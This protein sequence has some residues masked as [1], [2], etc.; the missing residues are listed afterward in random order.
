MSLAQLSRLLP[1]PDEELQQ[2]LDYAKTLSKPE[3][4]DHFGNLLGESPDA[5]EFISSFNSRRQDPSGSSTS[6]PALTA[7]ISSRNTAIAPAPRG[8][9]GKRKKK[10]SIHTPAPRQISQVAPAPGAAYN[11]KDQH[12]D[13]MPGRPSQA[14]SSNNNNSS[15]NVSRTNTPPAQTQG[16]RKPKAPPSAAGTL[17][18]D[19]PK[20]N[21]KSNPASRT[22]TP[23]PSASAPSSSKPTK[24]TVTGGTAMHGASTAV[25]DLDAAIRAL[26]ITTSPTI[27]SKDTVSRKCDCVAT[28]HPLQTAAPNCLNCGKVICLKEGLGPCTHCGAGLLAADDIQAVISSLKA[29]RGREKMAADK[30]AHRKAEVSRTPAPFTKPRTGDGSG[31]GA[32][33]SG[34]EAALSAAE[35]QRD[36]LLDFQAENAKRTTVRDEAAD[37]DYSMA[38]GGGGGSMWASPEERAREL[39]RQQKIMR[40]MEWNAR[41]EYEKRQQVVSIDVARGKV[42]RK[43]AAVERPVW[44]DNDD[45]EQTEGLGGSGSGGAPL[46]ESSGNSLGGGVIGEGGAFSRNPLLGGVIKPM[47]DVRG[48]GTSEGRKNRQ[49]G[50]RKAQMDDDD[51][52]GVILDGGAYGGGVSG[53][54]DAPE[55]I[56]GGDEPACG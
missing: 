33:G 39:K 38:S 43:M 46:R 50:W 28:R 29:D 54:A 16:H 22:S 34:G 35:A 37:F 8:R 11:K 1:L 5:V 36:R 7:A 4:A 48:K 9:G 18:S 20:A 49:K 24:V 21:P 13:Y 31:A 14:T 47:Y 53:A 26:E 45:E 55:S 2:V 23:G 3:A 32:G 10:F 42:V 30:A 40:E 44:D 27:A 56:H 15:T 6:T 25:A 52:A 51:N 12:V 19:M 41:P 17:I